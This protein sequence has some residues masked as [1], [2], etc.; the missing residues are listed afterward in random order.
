ML[1][2]Y[3][4]QLVLPLWT[5]DSSSRFNRNYLKGRMWALYTTTIGYIA[6]D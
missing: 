2:A 6:L 3:L 4:E 1:L 5:K